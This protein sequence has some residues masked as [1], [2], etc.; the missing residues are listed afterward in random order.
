MHNGAAKTSAIC[1]YPRKYLKE[2]LLP[3][4][5]LLDYTILVTYTSSTLMGLSFL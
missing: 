4:E 1:I 2:P 5:C 3:C